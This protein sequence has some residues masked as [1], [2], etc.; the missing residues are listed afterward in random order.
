[1]AGGLE[2]AQKII[3]QLRD[4]GRESEFGKPSYLFHG[5]YVTDTLSKVMSTPFLVLSSLQPISSDVPCTNS[6][7]SDTRS[8]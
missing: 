2:G 3:K 5:Q 1:M 4:E 6:C 7:V 8:S